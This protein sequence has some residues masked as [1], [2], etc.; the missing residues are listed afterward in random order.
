MPS[1]GAKL[2]N[3]W[4]KTTQHFWSSKGAFSPYGPEMPHN[5]LHKVVSATAVNQPLSWETAP[6]HRSDKWNARKA[7]ASALAKRL[8]NYRTK[9]SRA[10]SGADENARRRLSSRC[11]SVS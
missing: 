3:R 10:N 6:A 1:D 5:P 8:A 4:R 9:L 7:M 11:L 2:P